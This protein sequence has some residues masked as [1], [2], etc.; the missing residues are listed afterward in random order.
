MINKMALVENRQQHL[1]TQ[2]STLDVFTCAV[3]PWCYV[4]GLPVVGL[5]ALFL[6]LSLGGAFALF[7]PLAIFIATRVVIKHLDSERP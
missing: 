6:F 2:P 3:K 7:G 4:V 5:L 1:N